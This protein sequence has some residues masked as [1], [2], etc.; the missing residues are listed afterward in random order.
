MQEKVVYNS[1]DQQQISNIYMTQEK[2]SM[3]AS[4]SARWSQRKKKDGTTT[5][6]KNKQN[7]KHQEEVKGSEKQTARPG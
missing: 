3:K 6:A 2:K 1:G 4:N 7:D 5:R